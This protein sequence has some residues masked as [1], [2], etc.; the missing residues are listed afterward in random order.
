VRERWASV[1]AL[2]P[3]VRTRRRPSD[4]EAAC[5]ASCRASGIRVRL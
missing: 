3:E 4:N 1:H 5:Y 2:P